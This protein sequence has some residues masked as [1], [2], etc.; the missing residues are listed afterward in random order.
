[1]STGN[2]GDISVETRELAQKLIKKIEGAFPKVFHGPK[3]RWYGF[4]K[5]YLSIRYT[6]RSGV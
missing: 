1:M 4:Y 3:Y 2:T 5:G 6:I